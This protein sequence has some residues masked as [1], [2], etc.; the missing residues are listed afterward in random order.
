M[1]L[2]EYR[3]TIQEFE[4]QI[5]GKDLV[6]WGKNKSCSE[7]CARYRVKYIIDR[8]DELCD[9]NVRGIPI[10]LPEKLY[11]LEPSKT[12]VLLCMAESSYREALRVL[13][14]VGI[15]AVFFWNVLQEAFLGEVSAALY[16][17]M[18]QIRGIQKILWDD[19]SR[20]VLHEVVCR[21]ICGL[22]SGYGDLK[23]RNE[24]QYIFLPA[25]YSKREGT[26]LDLGGYIGDSVDRFV[27]KLGDEVS[28]I[29]TFEAWE[30]NI[31]CLEERRT[32]LKEYWK[33]ELEIVPC[34]AADRRGTV[35]FS[36]HRKAAGCFLSAFKSASCADIVEQVN[37]ETRT[38]DE[39]IPDTE[40]VRY[41]KM[42]IEGAEYAALKG[43]KRTIMREKP[44]LAI[45]IY[46]SACDYY[47]LAELILAY[48]PEYK[49]AV[50]H[51][52]DR[53]VDTVLYA[54]IQEG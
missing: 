21:R 22:K 27:N 25:L 15:F 29:Y 47:R 46:H 40:K 7:L 10:S 24:I 11:A 37:V 14:E 23:V 41:I 17:H 33:G 30:E 53:H 1:R 35:P 49:L 3:Q 44:G 5:A 6:I 32:S 54:W 2:P 9:T 20:K 39:V 51:H 18:E 31:R 19:Y 12:V 45:S 8:N 34:A 28:K 52:K 13:D 50:R 48:V 43:A 4:R 42:D 36:I 16:D 26:I 38:I